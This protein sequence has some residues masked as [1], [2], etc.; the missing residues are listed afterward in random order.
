MQLHEERPT[1]LRMHSTV[2]MLDNEPVGIWDM[3]EGDVN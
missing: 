2:A 3:C 1:R